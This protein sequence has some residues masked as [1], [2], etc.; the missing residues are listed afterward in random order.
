MILLAFGYPHSLTK[1]AP[2]MHFKK[3]SMA[4]ALYNW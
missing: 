1:K 4:G 2:G 3:L